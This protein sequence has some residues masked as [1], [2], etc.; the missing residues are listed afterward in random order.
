MSNKIKKAELISKFGSNASDS[1]SVASQCAIFT[2]RIKM[3]TEHMKINSKDNQTKRGLVALVNKRKKLLN[4]LKNKNNDLYV[5][6]I[7]ELE[8]RK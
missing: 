1:G 7:G 4:Y 5:K 6:L 2:A 8:I 3:L